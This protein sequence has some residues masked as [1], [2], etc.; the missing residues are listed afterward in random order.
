MTIST[1]EWSVTLRLADGKER[2]M[3]PRHV[4]MA[5]GVSGIPSLPDI[6]SLKG[7]NGQG[8][9]FQRL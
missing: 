7:F 2:D 6:P 8:R 3:R 5:T 9:A 1:G 4:V